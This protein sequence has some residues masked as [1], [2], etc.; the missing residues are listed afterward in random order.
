MKYKVRLA[1]QAIETIAYEIDVDDETKLDFIVEDLVARGEHELAIETNRSIE[2]IPESGTIE[3]I[4]TIAPPIA[5]PN[6]RL[7]E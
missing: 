2:A 7:V 6:L 4:E 1:Y 5:R 3:S